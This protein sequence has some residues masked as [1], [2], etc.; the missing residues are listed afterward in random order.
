MIDRSGPVVMSI[1][2]VQPAFTMKV[3]KIEEGSPASQAGLKP[4]QVI[5]SINGEKIKDIDPRIQL[6]NLITAAE[7]GDGALMFA[8]KGEAAPVVVKIPALGANRKTWPLDCPKSDKIVRN[9]AEYL[10]QPGSN[11]GFADIGML[12]LL[13]TGDDSDLAWPEFLR[14]IFDNIHNERAS[15]SF[16]GRI[17]VPCF[18]RIRRARFGK[19]FSYHADFP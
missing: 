3:G 1:E 5:E 2:L 12:F 9:F 10:K 14:Q 19:F 11:K 15:Y 13:S 18:K 6:G 17:L 4:G 7:G 16:D 8:V